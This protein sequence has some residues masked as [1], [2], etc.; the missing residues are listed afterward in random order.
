M[1]LTLT[2]EVREADELQFV[3]VI[4]A[5]AEFTYAAKFTF[6]PIDKVAVNKQFEIVKIAAVIGV[7]APN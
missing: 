4:F 7:M 3:K 2:E 5:F 1:M 6:E